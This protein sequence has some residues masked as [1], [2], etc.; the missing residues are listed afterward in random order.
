MIITEQ[1][2]SQTNALDAIGPVTLPRPYGFT[3]L[4][5]ALSTL[6]PVIFFIG[7]LAA[8]FYLLLG[9]LKYIVAGSDDAKVKSARATMVHA[10][11]GLML[12]GMSIVFFNILAE[13]IP[14]LDQLF[15]L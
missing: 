10:I 5:E 13:I 15:F 8:F 3:S 7:G 14:G 2:K 9:A 12:L 4:E 11:V 1:L 6:I